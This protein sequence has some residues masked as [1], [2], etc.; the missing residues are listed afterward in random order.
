MKDN[1]KIGKHSLTRVNYT[2]IDDKMKKY[3]R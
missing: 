3:S 2:N 1:K